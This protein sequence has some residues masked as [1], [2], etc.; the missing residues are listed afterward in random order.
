MRTRLTIP[1]IS[2]QEAAVIP[3]PKGELVQVIETGKLYLGD[4]VTLLPN[5]TEVF[6]PVSAYLETSDATP[7]SIATIP[8]TDYTVG[9]VEV[10]LTAT[11]NAYSYSWIKAVAYKLIGGVLTIEGTTS[12]M[13]ATGSLGASACINNTSDLLT[14]DVTGLAATFIAWKISYSVNPLVSITPP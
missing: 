2:E 8:L 9:I 1:L 11:D 13:P 6:I 3:I 4:G 7:A 5:L 12:I 10:R 14:V